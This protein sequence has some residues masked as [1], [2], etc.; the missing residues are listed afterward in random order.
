MGN[1]ASILSEQKAE[2]VS[3]LRSDY[4]SY[5]A[6]G[7]SDEEMN[8]LLTKKF[9]ALQEM[10]NTRNTPK[11]KTGKFQRRPTQVGRGGRSATKSS[12]RRRSYGEENSPVRNQ[13]APTMVESASAP[14]L[15]DGADATSVDPK[16]MLPDAI[17][18][19]AEIA[20]NQ[21]NWDSV[22]QQPRC[23]ICEM[24]FQTQSKLDRH[25]KFSSL[26]AETLKKKEAQKNAAEN[27]IEPE[28]VKSVEGVDYKM[29]YSGT[30]FYWRTKSDI[31]F[32]IYTHKVA[33]CVEVIPYEVNKGREMTRIYL[34][35]YGLHSFVESSALQKTQDKIKA[36][37]KGGKYSVAI[38]KNQ[39]S[40][41]IEEAKTVLL[42][43][44][45]MERLQLVG[46]EV[47]YVPLSSDGKNIQ[48][49]IDRP[50]SLVPVPVVRRRRTTSEDVANKLQ[51]LAMDQAALAAATGKAQKM[52]ALMTSSVDSFK[53]AILAKKAAEAKLTKWQR[54]W[55]WACHRIVL[56]LAVE[57]YT[58][59][60]EAYEL[61]LKASSPSKR[62][63]EAP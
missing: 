15:P 4:E 36:S 10:M 48:I 56:Q 22:V 42:T 24:V 23:A 58:K 55:K 11:K 35:L 41:M 6:E 28:P 62:P 51:D 19:P 49:S 43:S 63:K 32:H 39:E 12:G 14:V 61:K 60:W 1:S 3:A 50:Q 59:Q 45:I 46:T 33:N 8:K 18:P 17:S 13:K 26:H 44:F 38:D 47:K 40:V 16:P 9:L 53:A 25:I 29:L 2:I 37:T 20:T 7:K 52:A 30:K 5:I 27:P 31:E 34:E 21:D 57:N 54:M